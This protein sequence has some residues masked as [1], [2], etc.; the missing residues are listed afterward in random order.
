MKRNDRHRAEGDEDSSPESISDSENWLNWN[1]DLDTP[2][3]SEDDWQAENESYKELDNC[4]DVSETLEVR[5]VSAAP[6][7]PGLIRPKRQSKKKVEK[8]L[9][10]VNIMETRR[11]KGVK[12]MYDRMH[13][14]II[15]KFTM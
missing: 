15:T 6:N 7:V 10:A 9:L 8:A 12:K 2:N 11:N 5:N 13:Q 14:C 4:S 3:D 1:G